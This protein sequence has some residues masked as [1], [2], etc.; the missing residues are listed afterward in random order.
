MNSS[1]ISTA[2]A[3]QFAAVILLLIVGLNADTA[4]GQYDPQAPEPM[5]K[6][7]GNLVI[8]GGGKVA[9]D[10]YK[11]F[12]DLAG[13]SQQYANDD[14]KSQIQLVHGLPAMALR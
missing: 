2:R 10:V 14:R 11:K 12:V 3:S 7:R 4:L 8:H 9:E 5:A 13:G 1:L 6:L